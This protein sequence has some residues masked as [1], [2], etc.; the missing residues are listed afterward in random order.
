ME[1]NKN[2]QAKLTFGLF[3]VYFFVLVWI[4]VFK[5]QFSFHD[6][7]HFRGL[8]LI[9]FAG[10]A[11]KNNRLDFHEI[12]LNVL[13]FA[14]FGLYLGMLR[15][16]RPFWK[17]IAAIAG[18]SLLFEL[19]QFLFAIGGADVTDLIGNTLG[20]AAGIGLY[21]LLSRVLRGNTEKVLNIAALAGTIGA[22]VLG[23]LLMNAVTYRFPAR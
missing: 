4:I 15:R 2:T 20:G 1:E 5:M 8:N 6:L 9:P 21:G 14:P 13:V 10:S 18:V 22:A 23:L 12:L 7:P 11:A 19:L 16:G 3:I 17:K